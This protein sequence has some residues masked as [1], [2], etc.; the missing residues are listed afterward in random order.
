[1]SS[2][3]TVLERCWASSPPTL[4]T[5]LL[6]ADLAAAALGQLAGRVDVGLEGRRAVGVGGREDDRARGMARGEHRDRR[7]R[8]LDDLR[9]RSHD[10]EGQHARAGAHADALLVDGQTARPGAGRRARRDRMRLSPGASSPVDCVGDADPESRE[11]LDRAA[12]GVRPRVPAPR[13][14]FVVGD[15]RLQPSPSPAVALQEP[16]R[17]LRPPRPGS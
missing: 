5:D 17:G 2:G 7:H 14:P 12:D 10:D 9:P 8:P 13:P 1:M 16:V 3:A 15:G 6:G 4:M 11:R